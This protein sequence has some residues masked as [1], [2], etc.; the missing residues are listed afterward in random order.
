[1]AARHDWLSNAD[2]VDTLSWS[3]TEAV[4][5]RDS[6]WRRTWADGGRRGHRQD[7]A[8]QDSRC[9]HG[10]DV[11]ARQRDRFH[12]AARRHARRLH[13]V[14]PAEW[15]A[16]LIEPARRAGS[17]RRL[18][19]DR[20]CGRR[21]ASESRPRRCLARAPDRCGSSIRPA[22]NRIARCS[23][24]LPACSTR[25]ITWSSDGKSLILGTY[26]WNGDIFLAERSA[27]R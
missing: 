21:M 11:V 20:S 15:R 27:P 7:H 19:M 26:R 24:C 2:V 13:S 1:M 17:R 23:I 22:R 4:G 3:P 18:P 9:S 25:G 12:R 16:C 14:D 5:L 6:E 8:A 10:P